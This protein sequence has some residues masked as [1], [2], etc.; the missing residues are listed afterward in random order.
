ML[1]CLGKWLWGAVCM[2]VL[3]FRV[4]NCWILGMHVLRCKH[5]LLIHSECVC[6]SSCILWYCN[7]R[8]QGCWIEIV[9]FTGRHC[10]LSD[11]LFQAW[12]GYYIWHAFNCRFALVYFG[13]YL[14]WFQ[15]GTYWLLLKLHFVVLKIMTMKAKFTIECIFCVILL[16]ETITG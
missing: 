9:L 3:F 6:H 5:Y 14:S 11:H 16:T 15:N 8:G 13:K 7:I 1:Y 12:N 10:L 4:C 2:E